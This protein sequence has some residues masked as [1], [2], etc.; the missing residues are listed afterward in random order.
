VLGGLLLLSF[1]LDWTL[2]PPRGVRLVHGLLSLGILGWALHRFLV[3]PLRRLLGDEEI[4]LAVEAR[5]PRLQDRLVGALQWDRILADPGCGESRAFMEAAA[6][7]AAANLRSVRVED[8]T[9]A[10]PARGAAALGG[11]VAL[12][13]LGGAAAMGDATALW[14]RRSLLLLDEPW[15]RRTTL[16]V[17]GFDPARPRVVTIGDDL[18]VAVRVEGVVPREGVSI[19]Y[20]AVAGGGARSDR[21]ARPML[22]SA[23][24]PRAFAFVFHEV[25]ASFEFWCTGGDDDDADPVLSVRAL[26]PPAIEA[27]TA[28]L[29]FPART[30]LPPERRA[31]G[32]LEVPAGTRVDLAVRANVALR[33]AAFSLPAGSPGRPLAVEPDGR[34]VRIPVEVKETADWRLDMEGVDGARSVPSRNTRRF[35]ALPDPRPDLRLLHPVSRTY[36]VPDGRIPV[37]VRATD[38][39]GLEAVSLEVVPGRGREAA[40]IP[41]FT[42]PAAPPAP[43]SGAP[44][45]PPAKPLR[46]VVRYRL[47]DLPTISP[48]EGEKGIPLDEEVQVRALAT[49]NGGSSA[50]TDPVAI[51]I[52]D[53]AEILRRLTQKQS[54]I[55]EDLDAVRRHL[56]AARAGAARARDSLAAGAALTPADRTSLHGPSVMASRSVRESAALADAL[57]EVVLDYALNRLVQDRVA[58]ERLVAVLDEWLR[59]D[60]GDPA[61]VFKPGLWRRLAAARASREV[62]DGGILASLLEA[63]GLSDRLSAGPAADLRERM[64]ALAAGRDPDPPAAA[65]GAVRAADEALALVEEIGY[66]LQQWETMHEIL[67]AVRSLEQQQES[68]H[69]GLGGGGKEPQGR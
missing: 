34:S 43:P 46:E 67:E 69:R 9:E 61:V 47:L 10:R 5:A 32:D 22:Q 3:L 64:E 28:D 56:E 6:E 21:D 54:R 1:L 27:V 11:A 13:V 58:T 39:Y 31:E 41:L 38:N 8:L 65:A 57:G 24:D 66:H 59:E 29:V 36:S 19:H 49:D 44:A 50:A 37:K 26:V 30:G 33:S 25:P 53:A 20:R 55:R 35:T 12:L 16:V 68:I 17:L 48:P 52:T 40:S 23:D 4:A 51:Q 2:Q 42:A 7:E 18:P 62:D 45:P 14:A 60:R 15:P 63:L